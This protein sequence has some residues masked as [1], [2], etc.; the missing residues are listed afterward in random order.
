MLH[1]F[2]LRVKIEKD[3]WAPCEVRL[4]PETTTQSTSIFSRSWSL[5]NCDLA[6]EN[7]DGKIWNWAALGVPF[8]QLNVYLVAQ[9]PPVEISCLL[10]I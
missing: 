4:K 1:F 10:G 3:E 2:G 6:D 8:A 5:W 7:S 9:Q